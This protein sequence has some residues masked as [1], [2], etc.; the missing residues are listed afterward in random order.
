[1]DKHPNGCEGVVCS[2]PTDR[3]HALCWDE[4][5]LLL[6]SEVK[7]VLS[8]NSWA[9]PIIKGLRHLTRLYMELLVVSGLSGWVV[10]I[11]RVLI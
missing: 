8:N 10:H 2:R 9:L 5:C 1:M 11:F 7:N 6:I 3:E 4:T